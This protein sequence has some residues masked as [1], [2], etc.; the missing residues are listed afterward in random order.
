MTC[1]YS[2]E[3]ARTK[4]KEVL[5]TKYCDR[6][7]ASSRC[8]HEQTRKEGGLTSPKDT[9]PRNPELAKPKQSEGSTTSNENMHASWPVNLPSP[10]PSVEK[11]SRF[12]FEAHTRVQHRQENG[13]VLHNAT[14]S[15]MSASWQPADTRVTLSVTR[16][17]SYTRPG[18]MGKELSTQF[19]W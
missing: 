9:G 11:P 4:A 7:G 1:L 18:P 12:D 17:A 15:H 8:D 16:V 6:A 10:T 19:N 3:G 14:S 13:G 5:D 2:D